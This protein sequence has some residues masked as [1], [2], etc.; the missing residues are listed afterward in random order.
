MQAEP[1]LA[2]MQSSKSQQSRELGDCNPWPKRTTGLEK[3]KRSAAD[4][5]MG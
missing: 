3:R 2:A 4:G 1:K 5:K